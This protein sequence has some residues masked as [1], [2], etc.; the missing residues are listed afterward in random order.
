L[1]TEVRVTL[2]LL[3]AELGPGVGTAWAPAGTELAVRRRLAGDERT[4]AAMTLVAAVE[5]AWP[6]AAAVVVDMCVAGYW[7]GGYAAQPRPRRLQ[8]PVGWGTLGYALPAAIGPA[9][10]GLPTLAVVGD[11]GAAMG[12]GELATYQQ[13]KLPVTLLVVDDGGYGMLRYDGQRAD[14]PGAGTE[15]RGPHWPTLADAYGLR[16]LTVAGVDDL[17]GTLGEAYRHNLAGEPVLV[18]LPLSLL[19]PRTTSPRWHEQ[20]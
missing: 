8:Y 15:L 14:D 5:Q 2:E 1:E 17:A 10:A 7:V 20:P 11:G 9:A 3:L 4:A 13:Q 16:A 12:V 6:A 18:H 19:P